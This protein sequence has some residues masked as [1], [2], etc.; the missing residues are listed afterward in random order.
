MTTED[1]QD[2][3]ILTRLATEAL[4]P[5]QRHA[6]HS[7][8]RLDGAGRTTDSSLLHVVETW[9]GGVPGVRARGELDLA[10]A[11]DLTAAVNRAG[12]WPVGQVADPGR[13]VSFK[14]DL[15][16]ITFL[17]LTGLRIL[18]ALHSQISLDGGYVLAVTAPTTKGCRR[19][20]GLAV[21]LGWLPAAFDPVLLAS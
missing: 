11:P 16:G 1:D 8:I 21:E 20:L 3:P 6:P 17:D 14:L 4:D 5:G 12:R 19:L 7:V 10:T 15:E 9:D 13:D 2:G 18:R